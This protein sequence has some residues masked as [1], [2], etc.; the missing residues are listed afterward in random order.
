MIVPAATFY[1]YEAKYSRN[2][3]RYEFD[4]GLPPETL[5]AMS[6]YAVR[7]FQGVG[8]RHL[9]RVDFIVDAQHKPWFLE[10]NTLPGFTD[11]SLLPKA[12]AQAGYDMPTLCDRL[13][14]LALKDGV[15]R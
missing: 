14:R 9:A 3:T 13:V 8:C 4:T 2:D 11:H 7:V 10:I 5:D 1:D 15:S 6:R 12:A